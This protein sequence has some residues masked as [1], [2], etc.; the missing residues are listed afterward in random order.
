MCFCTVECTVWL[1][2]KAPSRVQWYS[3]LQP[4]VFSVCFLTCG[5][6]ARPPLVFTGTQKL[7]PLVLSECF[8]SFFSPAG[9]IHEARVSEKQKKEC[10][11]MVS[12]PNSDQIWSLIWSLVTNLNEMAGKI[13]QLQLVTGYYLQQ[14]L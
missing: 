10:P 8:F 3:K 12:C 13:T 11:N 9:R 6:R 5:V 7:H 2:R 4:L 14:F 1:A